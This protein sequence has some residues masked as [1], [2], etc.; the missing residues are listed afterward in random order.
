[1]IEVRNEKPEIGFRIPFEFV[2][3]AYA[4]IPFGNI[5]INFF[6]RF[7]LNSSNYAR[8]RH[9]AVRRDSDSD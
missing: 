2:T 6:P 7:E 9:G 4:S 1:M 5:L 3:F 8:R